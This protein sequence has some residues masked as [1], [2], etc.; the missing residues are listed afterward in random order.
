MLL[1]EN[2]EIK[3][4]FR[5]KKIVVMVTKLK[6]LLETKKN[7]FKLIF[8]IVKWFINYYLIS[9]QDFSTKFRI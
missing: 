5:E 9:Y 8:I 7:V 4:N 1:Q 6:I 2:Y 3:I